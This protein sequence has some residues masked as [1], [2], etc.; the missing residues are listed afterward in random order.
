MDDIYY[1]EFLSK[2]Y[3]DSPFFGQARSREIDKFNNFYYEALKNEN[4][5]IL[6]FGSATGMLSIPLA[7]AGHKLDSVDIS[8]YMQSVLS[9]KLK[10]EDKSVADNIN[11]I[12]A[13]AIQYKGEHLYNSIVMPEGILI[14]IPD[15][16]L[17]KELLDSCYRNLDKHGRIYTDFFQPRYKIIYNKT[18]SECTRFRTKTGDLY[19]LDINFTNNE[20]TQLQDWNVKYTKIENGEKVNEIEVDVTFRYIFYSEIQLL[21]KQTGF[22]VIDIDVNY[23]DGRG[24]SVIAEKV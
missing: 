7:R 17:Q 6:E 22:K 21:L 5:R 23:A 18:L 2:I 16:E 9:E 8:P 15:A 10:N 12:V 24:F 3:D 19:L 1:E 20:Y 13:D 14:A 4:R 11:Q